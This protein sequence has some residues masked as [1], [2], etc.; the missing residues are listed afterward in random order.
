MNWTPSARLGAFA[1]ET[2][3]KIRIGGR[4]NNRHHLPNRS[5]IWLLL[6]SACFPPVLRAQPA[7]AHPSAIASTNSTPGPPAEQ[8]AA[9]QLEMT[10]AWRRVVQIVNQPVKAYAR[11]ANIAAAVYSPGWFH[12]GATKP[13]FNSVDVRQSQELIYAKHQYVTSD[14]SPG[15]VFLGRDLE[16]NTMTK[17]FYVNR[18]LPKKKLSE[19]EMLEINRLYRVIGH[20]ET[21]IA[22]LQPSSPP[23][24]ATSINSETDTDPLEASQQQWAGIRGIPRE[25]R[26]L[27]GGIAIG[28]LIVIVSA[29]RLLKRRPH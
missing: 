18:S 26:A 1:R 20:C 3:S 28:A 5:L 16:F 14:L 12:E 15:M 24:V 7:T 23:E 27:Y 9:L 22:R 4:T 29:G 13:D 17:Y 25:K 21:E 6:L 10:N 8:T 2:T 11:S 19:A